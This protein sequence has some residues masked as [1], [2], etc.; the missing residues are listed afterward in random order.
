MRKWIIA[1]VLISFLPI[2]FLLL[3]FNHSKA[4]ANEQTRVWNIPAGIFNADKNDTLEVLAR[5]GINV[6][7]V[8]HNL[9]FSVQPETKSARKIENF[10]CSFEESTYFGIIHRRILRVTSDSNT[11][12]QVDQFV[13]S[14]SGK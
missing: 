1:V 12:E 5:H 8:Q 9:S 7:S 3:G 2:S 4:N 10:D 13:K 11:L 14:I 6:G